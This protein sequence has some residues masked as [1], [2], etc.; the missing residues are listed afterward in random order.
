MHL[1]PYPTGI[2]GMVSMDNSNDRDTDF[3]L[4]AMADIQSGEFQV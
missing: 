2:T 1:V 3:N 4:W